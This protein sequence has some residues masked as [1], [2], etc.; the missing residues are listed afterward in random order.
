MTA[1]RDSRFSGGLTRRS[2][3]AGFRPRHP[4]LHVL[5][6]LSVVLSLFPGCSQELPSGTYFENPVGWNR[7]IDGWRGKWRHAYIQ[8]PEKPAV[9]HYVHK[10]LRDKKSWTVAV[11]N[12]VVDHRIVPR[13]IARNP[14]VGSGEIRHCQHLDWHGDRMPAAREIGSSGE[15]ITALEQQLASR[16]EFSVVSRS[17]LGFVLN[18]RD[19]QR[20]LSNPQDLKG[21]ASIRGAD[22][23]VFASGGGLEYLAYSIDW[24]DGGPGRLLRATR[25]RDIWL[26][27]RMVDVRDGTLL[28]SASALY[29]PGHLL[30]YPTLMHYACETGDAMAPHAGASFETVAYFLLENLVWKMRGNASG[31]PDDHRM[32]NS[33]QLEYYKLRRQPH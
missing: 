13:G 24:N 14:S 5:A 19:V 28:W 9:K 15:I 10:R 32:I 29:E 11:V 31:L 18:E 17:Q 4:A 30:Y 8:V 6:P 23:I 7:V 26:Q 21:L 12:A 27:V 33:S 3:G 25:V 20:A 1:K 16:E 22:A 2:D